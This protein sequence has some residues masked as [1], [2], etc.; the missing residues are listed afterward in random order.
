MTA[1]ETVRELKRVVRKYDAFVRDLRAKDDEYDLDYAMGVF[2]TWLIDDNARR[3]L[4]MVYSR[5]LGKTIMRIIKLLHHEPL[6]AEELQREL[7][8][9]AFVVG[10]KRLEL[11]T[12]AITRCACCSD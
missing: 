3:R 10:P 5:K 9:L 12:A 6:S 7:R 4:D 2:E 11:S 8:V 1:A